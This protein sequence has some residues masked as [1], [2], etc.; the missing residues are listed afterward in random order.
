LNGFIHEW[1]C[2]ERSAFSNENRYNNEICS[3]FGGLFISRY[4]K[5]DSELFLFSF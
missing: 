3:A 1:E 5:S 2:P 4:L